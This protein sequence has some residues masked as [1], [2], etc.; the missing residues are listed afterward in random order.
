[1]A[2]LFKVH[3]PTK[4]HSYKNAFTINRSSCHPLFPFFLFPFKDDKLIWQKEESRI[5]SEV[6]T[7]RNARVKKK[8]KATAPWKCCHLASVLMKAWR[9]GFL[10]KK[11]NLSTPSFL[12]S[13]ENILFIFSVLSQIN[14]FFFFTL[15][16]EGLGLCQSF[17]LRILFYFTLPSVFQ[18]SMCQFSRK[19][20]VICVISSIRLALQPNQKYTVSD[21]DIWRCY[22]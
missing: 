15:R 19:A 5:F 3:F 14:H 1:M 16:W 11:K 12:L 17:R 8:K 21:T 6:I 22:H 9:T 7:G 20:A 13:S 4:I 10:K 2:F 18:N